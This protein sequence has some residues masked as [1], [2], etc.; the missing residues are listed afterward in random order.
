VIERKPERFLWLDVETTGLKPENDLLLEVAAWPT[1]SA[2]PFDLSVDDRRSWVVHHDPRPLADHLSPFTWKM[3]SVNGL[4]GEVISAQTTLTML[5]E[6]LEAMCSTNYTWYLAGNSVHFDRGFLNQ[7]IYRFTERLSHRI[8]D[9]SSLLLVARAAGCN[10]P[11]A[12]PAHRAMDD[13]RQSVASAKEAIH[14]LRNRSEGDTP[15]L[16]LP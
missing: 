1:R 5:C 9:V 10:L 7:K 4:L 14:A 2:D 16:W 3:H 13:V 15:G 8:L 11:K 12:E 6:D